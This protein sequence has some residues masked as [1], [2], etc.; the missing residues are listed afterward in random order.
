MDATRT[1]ELIAIC[2]IVGT[3]VLTGLSTGT[4]GPGQ[5]EATELGD[6]DATV[7]QITLPLDEFKLDKGRFGTTVYYLRMPD[8]RIRV[9]NVTDSPRLVYRIQTPELGIDKAKTRILPDRTHGLV[10]VTG[11]D[12]A[13]PAGQLPNGSVSTQVT[14]RVQS[15]ETDRTVYNKSIAVEAGR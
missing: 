5:Y 6:G 10:T 7:S 11:E 15:F 8:A 12:T 2:L 9:Q 14:V 13:I 3:T 4:N 1:V